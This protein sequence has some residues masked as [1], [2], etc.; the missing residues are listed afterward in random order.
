MQFVLSYFDVIKGPSI[1]LSFPEQ[2]PKKIKNTIKGLFDLEAQDPFFEF[3]IKDEDLKITNIN[4][5]IPSLWAR[6]SLEMVMLSVITE[7]KFNNEKFYSLLKEASERIATRT[8]IYKSLY[9]EDDNKDTEIYQKYEELKRIF[10][11]FN[12]KFEKI[13]KE[14]RIMELVASKELSVSGAYKVFGDIM[15]DIISCLLQQKPLVLC[16]DFDASTALLSIFKRVFLDIFTFDDDLIIKK[17]CADFA[18]DSYVINMKYGIIESGEISNDAN[19]AIGRYLQEAE[20]IGNN[21]AAIIFLRQ[22]LSIFMKVAD[23]LEQI[24]TEKQPEKRILKDIRK[25]M[26][27][28][29]KSDEL[30]AIQLILKSRG[31]EDVADKIIMSKFDRF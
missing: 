9:I 21:D 8:N 31:R 30:Y 11:E 23:L 2:I 28:K 25:H 4:F 10:F 29:I 18:P 3:I 15:I 7:I 13:R 5:M 6:G 17:E 26:R 16:E 22:R 24:L 1:F 14:I 27:M 19:D 12:D 20:K